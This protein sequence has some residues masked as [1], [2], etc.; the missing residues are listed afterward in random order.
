MKTYEFSS[1]RQ[2]FYK[3][4]SNFPGEPKITKTHVNFPVEAKCTVEKIP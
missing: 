3:K 1:R 4:T 2:F